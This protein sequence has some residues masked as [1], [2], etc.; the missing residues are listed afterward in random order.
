LHIWRNQCRILGI[1]FLDEKQLE[2]LATEYAI[3]AGPIALALGD[4]KKL[5]DEK[6]IGKKEIFKYLEKLLEGHKTFINNQG[7]K[8]PTK[9]SLLY[10]PDYL[11]T[12]IPV[13]KILE[14]L[15]KFQAHKKDTKAPLDFQN[16]NLLFYGPSGTGKTE[17]AKFL[18][19]KLG[20][21]L[22]TK[23]VSDLFSK[24]LGESEGN[25]AN[26]F[27]QVEIE[28]SILFLDECDSF[29]Q[30]RTSAQ[31]G[32]EI[33]RTNELLVAMENFKGILI[34]STNLKDNLDGAISRR[35]VQKVRFSFLSLEQAKNVYSDFFQRVVPREIEEELEGLQ[36]LTPG[37]F[38]IVKRRMILE[39]AMSD[40]EIISLLKE[41]IFHKKEMKSKIRI[42]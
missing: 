1:T 34:C 11:N 32:H 28:G 19:T 25:I 22:V 4:L 20:L 16:Y 31:M 2:T 17:Y 14:S 7:D 29:F 9:V 3:N 12:S 8:N 24:W 6:L 37:D 33:T 42:K 30:D 27:K 23:R 5:V 10:R 13:F 36:F 38:S 35:F 40:R 15:K 26:A 21:N 18:A 39:G 41:E